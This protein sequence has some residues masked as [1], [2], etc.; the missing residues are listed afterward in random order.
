MLKLTLEIN[1]QPKTVVAAS[2]ESLANVL[3]ENLGLTGT[4]VG[5]GE[6]QCGC[7]NVILDGKLVRSCVTKMSK[8]P[9]GASVETIEGV[10]TPK[11][12]HPLQVA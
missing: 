7:C 6:G 12:P 1:G 11:D 10:G 8:V 2:D 9:N 5:C 4:K 3:R